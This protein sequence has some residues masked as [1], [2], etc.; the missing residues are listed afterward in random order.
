MIPTSALLILTCLSSDENRPAQYS[1]VRVTD[2]IGLAEQRGVIEQ[3]R[4]LL[5][6]QFLSNF[7]PE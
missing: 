5:R 2:G 3:M 4:D 1:F 6:I 7:D